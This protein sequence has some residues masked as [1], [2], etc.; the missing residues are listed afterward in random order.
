MKKMIV[1]LGNPGRRYQN[2]PHNIGFDV[3]DELAARHGFR[4]T[5]AR[6]VEAEMA[7]G[8]IAD[9]NCLLLKP[10]TFMN[11]SGDAIAP[12]VWGD[13]I[14]FETHVLILVD[15]VDI[16]LGRL[17]LRATGTSGG[18]RGLD[19]IIQRMS[20]KNFARLRCGVGPD[21][22]EDPDFYNRRDRDLADY[23]LARWPAGLRDKVSTMTLNAANAVETWL[24]KPMADAMK[25]VNSQG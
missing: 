2:T 11:L 12:F 9:T 7:E 3:A 20:T 1:G 19:S 17:R 5:A 13:K 8:R 14:P 18:H 22:Q 15:D 21:K 23:V 25:E 4:W 6:R 24:E 10:S 16:P